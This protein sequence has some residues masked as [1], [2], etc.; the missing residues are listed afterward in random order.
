M[1]FHFLKQSEK[2]PRRRIFTL[3]EL[4]VVVGIIAILAGMLL[5][6]LASAREKGKGISCT[7]NL[8][9]L[10]K[11][12]C[13]YGVDTGFNMPTYEGVGVRG[14]AAGYRTWLGFTPD[15]NNFNFRQGFM[16][17]YLNGNVEALLCPD[18][19]LNSD[20]HNKTNVAKGAGYGHN[21]YGVGS[22]TYWGG[23]Y[24]GAG[25]KVEKI[26]APG[27]TI[28]F[29]DSARGYDSG[30]TALVGLLTVYPRYNPSAAADF[31]SVKTGFGDMAST[32]GANI[33]FRHLKRGNVG[34]LDGHVSTE[35]ATYIKPTVTAGAY[36]IG[37]FGPDDNSLWDPWNL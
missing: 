31:H 23:K 16:A 12:N 15:G 18:W 9:Q 30:P 24:P 20:H 36:C 33:H 13:S 1:R 5:P 6:A 27:S 11:A 19:L 2:L 4:L 8:G 17:E 3:I 7:G 32:Y 10:I 37:S 35:K 14:P 28:V 34:W 29:A 21:Y 26:A 25:A 22:W